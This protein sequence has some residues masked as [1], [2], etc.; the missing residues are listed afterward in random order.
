MCQ[1]Y[2]MIL[3]QQ[4]DQQASEMLLLWGQVPP[5]GR[6]GWGGVRACTV[7]RAL[8]LATLCAAS[9]GDEQLSE[10]S[11]G[12]LVISGSSAGSAGPSLAPASTTVALNDHYFGSFLPCDP[13]LISLIG[14][15]RDLF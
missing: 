12:M 2:L 8:T 3:M 7:A 11:H 14:K 9:L 15:Q 5:F 10:G 6:P 13:L 4:P 1:N